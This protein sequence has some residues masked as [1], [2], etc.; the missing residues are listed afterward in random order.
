MT[1]R[2]A[3][4]TVGIELVQRSFAFWAIEHFALGLALP[5]QFDHGDRALQHRLH[6]PRPFGTQQVGEADFVE[7]PTD[8]G[9]DPGA[10]SVV[11]GD[12]GAFAAA[13]GD[14]F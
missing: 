10:L 6:S 11:D 8:R 4:P 5:Q 14:R 2:E 7:G 12:I 13:D 3:A 9:V 1:H